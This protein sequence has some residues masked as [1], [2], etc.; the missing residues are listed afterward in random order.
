MTTALLCIIAALIIAL[1][2]ARAGQE[3][4]EKSEVVCEI[5]ARSKSIVILCGQ[6]A[7]ALDRAL[8]EWKRLDADL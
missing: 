8:Q 5:L 6:D 3:R 4:L 2:D 1:I 7:K